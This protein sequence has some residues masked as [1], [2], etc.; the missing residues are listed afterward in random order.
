MQGEE[1]KQEEVGGK[2]VEVLGQV[3]VVQR[4]L[5]GMLDPQ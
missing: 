3:E 2:L 1:Q 5:E 4:M